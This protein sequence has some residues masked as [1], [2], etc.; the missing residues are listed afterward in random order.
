MSNKKQSNWWVYLILFA[1]I[2]LMIIP[3]I[4]TIVSSFKP[5]AEITGNFFGLPKEFTLDNYQ[6]LFQDG[7]SQYFFN[8]SLLTVVGVGLIVVIVPM[9]AFSIAR[10]MKRSKAFAIMY[11]F[12]IIG[13]FVPFQV[14]MLPMTKLMSVLDLNNHV[15]LILLYLAY[16]IP[17]TLFLY[18]GYIKAIVPED[19][20][21]AA[22]ID[23][24]DKFTM[25]WKIIFPLL[26]PM[27]ATVLIINA[28]WIWNDFLL[29]LLVLNKDQNLW[30]LP[31]F[32]YNYQGMYFSDYGPSFASYVVGI[33]PILIVYLIFQKNIISGMTSGAVK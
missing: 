27:H 14:I 6:R 3:L 20:D 19:M 21:E 17:Q 8:S 15:G 24:C 29:P 13:I 7:I 33:I 4:V 2:M 32:Q 18:V 26:K 25:Y 22:A 10:H 23:G 1:G 11:I 5:T 9:A 16:A 31:L 28:L 30:T 12:L